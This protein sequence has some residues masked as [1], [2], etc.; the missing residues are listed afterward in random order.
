MEWPKQEQEHDQFLP[1]PREPLRSTS[2]PS[3]RP[4]WSERMPR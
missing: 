1:M 3:I 2:T 4:A